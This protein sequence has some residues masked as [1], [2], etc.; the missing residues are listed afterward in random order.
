MR[1]TASP[2]RFRYWP[3]SS[4][5]RRPRALI[6][7]SKSRSTGASQPDF[8]WRRIVSVFKISPHRVGVPESP[9]LVPETH[10]GGKAAYAPLRRSA[11]A[12]ATWFTASSRGR[13]RPGGPAGKEGGSREGKGGRRNNN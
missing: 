12:A 4:A 5:P 7:R 13:R 11:L 3:I 6:G 1:S 9:C 2:W 10:D 8:A